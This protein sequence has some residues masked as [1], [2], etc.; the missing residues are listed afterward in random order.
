MFH[1][2]GQAARVVCFEDLSIFFEANVPIAHEVEAALIKF[3]VDQLFTGR[4]RSE[5]LFFEV[6]GRHYGDLD[7]A[8][9]P[10]E[11]H[12]F[13]RDHEAARGAAAYLVVKAVLLTLDYATQAVGEVDRIGRRAELVVDDEQFPGTVADLSICFLTFWRTNCSP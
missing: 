8:S 12:K 13:L 6:I 9:Q 2:R 1:V 7:L 5:I 4:S 3:E 11:L 10:H